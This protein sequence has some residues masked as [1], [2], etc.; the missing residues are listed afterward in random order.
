MNP[1]MV[2]LTSAVVFVGSIA[3]GPQRTP[4]RFA[5]IH[6]GYYGAVACGVGALTHSKFLT[7][8]GAFILADDATQH[9]YQ[10]MNNNLDIVSPLNIGYRVTIGAAVPVQ[11]LNRW[12]DKAVNSLLR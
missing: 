1:L 2:C 3:G 11:R 12:L 6:H 7:K 8:V 4:L 5:E 10:R 9:L